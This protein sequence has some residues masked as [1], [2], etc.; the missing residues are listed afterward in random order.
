MPGNITKL[1]FSEQDTKT[2]WEEIYHLIIYCDVFKA[3][4]DHLDSLQHT[5]LVHCSSAVYFES[6]NEEVLELNHC[7]LRI[8]SSCAPGH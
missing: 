8:F 6:C 5:I 7:H 3:K 4:K 2:L 1:F